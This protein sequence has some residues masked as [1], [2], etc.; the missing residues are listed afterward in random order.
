MV[1]PL[2][3]FFCTFLGR[4]HHSCCPSNVLISDRIPPCHSAHPSQ[5]PHLIYFLSCMLSSR[6]CPV[7]CTIQQSWSDHIFENLPLQL[8]WHPPVTQH[9]TASLPVSPSCT[10]CEI[11]VVMPP[12]S[13]TLAPIYLKRCTRC[14]S[15]PRIL[16]GSLPW[17]LS[18]PNVKAMN[19]V[20]G[21]LILMP[22]SSKALL[23]VSKYSVM[24]VS[25]S[26]YRI[27]SCN[28][29]GKY[30][31]CLSPRCC[32]CWEALQHAVSEFPKSDAEEFL[33]HSPRISFTFTIMPLQ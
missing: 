20:F 30:I 9:S 23:R 33:L 3:L 2:Q 28:T 13:S 17:P 26:P 16:T 25:S 5:H 24:S 31:M 29:D 22:L 14:S 18:C 19:W 21:L 27:H 1:V 6:C 12:V 8:H 7:L 11:Y 4:L 15:S 10:L 32:R